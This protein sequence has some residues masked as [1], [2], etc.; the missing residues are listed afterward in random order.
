MMI[1]SQDIQHHL[2][3]WQKQLSHEQGFSPKTLEA[4][5][6]DVQQFMTYFSETKPFS[7]SDFQTLTPRDF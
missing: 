5:R 7:L 6:R 4:Y 2:T 3:L 1:L